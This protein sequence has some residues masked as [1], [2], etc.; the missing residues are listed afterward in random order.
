MGPDGRHT[1]TKERLLSA[2]LDLFA[3]KGV[4]AVS[5]RD[6]ARRVGISAAAFYN[7]YGSRNELLQAV[8]EYYRTTVL[9]PAAR[10]G[11]DPAS[12]IDTLSPP[13]LFTLLSE[14]FSEAMEN[15]ILAKLG[16]IISAE[17]NRNEVAA[18]IA[19]TDR[20][21]LVGFMEELFVQLQKKGLV[22]RGNAR[23]LGRMF[24][25]I[26]LGIV[27]DNMY[28]RLVKGMPVAEVVRRQNEEMQKFLAELLG[29]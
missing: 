11:P 1:D 6:I 5:I 24:G 12:L 9:E 16:K 15:P 20:R 3:E 7:H 25:Y 29:G 18:E 21:A 10:K 27:D 22:R 2:A 8:Y 14:R 17:K 26:Q 23:L 4:D 13:D 28:Y 19:Y